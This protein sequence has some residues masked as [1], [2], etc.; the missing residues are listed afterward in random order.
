MEPLISVKYSISVYYFFQLPNTQEYKIINYKVNFYYKIMYILM[1]NDDCNVLIIVI[2]VN[3]NVYINVNRIVLF[4]LLRDLLL[5]ILVNSIILLFTCLI[6]YLY[7][8]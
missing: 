4:H 5:M 3:I 1:M 7:E 6:V 8:V 2:L